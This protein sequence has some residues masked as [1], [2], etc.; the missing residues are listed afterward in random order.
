MGLQVL[1][2]RIEF[3]LNKG[4][5]QLILANFCCRLRTFIPLPCLADT[6]MAAIDGS[7]NEIGNQKMFVSD[8][9]MKRAKHPDATSMKRQ[10]LKHH[11]S[12]QFDLY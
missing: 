8:I 5:V 2:I 1:I 11:I 3:G 12:F 10:V 9:L 6:Y 4:F 7:L